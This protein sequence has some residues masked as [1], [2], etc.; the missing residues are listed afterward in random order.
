VGSISHDDIIG[1]IPGSRVYTSTGHQLLVFS[2]TLEDF[3]TQTRHATQVIYPK[4]LGIILAYGDI[5]PGSTVLEAGLGSGSLT[6]ALL[7]AVGESGNVTTYELRNDLADKAIKNIHTIHSNTDNLCIKIRD[8]YTGIE[9]I[10]L[11]RIV[12]DVPSP[13]LVVPHAE[14]ALISGGIFI[15]F[16]PTILQVH[17]L[18]EA[19]KA[20][21]YFEMSETFEVLVRPWSIGNQ[22]VR[23]EHR[24]VAH[25]GFITTSRKCEPRID[26]VDNEV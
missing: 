9:E 26:K 4:D 8:I 10:N 5:F 14:I 2:L 15:S 17:E 3:V 13:W 12:L 16:L 6:L 24:M 19:L 20:S 18:H 11:D 1:L 25:T 23:P 21:K 22:S 7:R